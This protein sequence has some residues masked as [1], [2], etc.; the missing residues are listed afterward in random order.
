LGNN[1]HGV[2]E[3]VR[4]RLKAEG[5]FTVAAKRCN[6]CLF[7]AERLTTKGDATGIIR[8]TLADDSFFSCH[9]FSGVVETENASSSKPYSPDS[10]CCRGWFD[11][12][13]NATLPGRM[14]QAFGI[15]KFVDED[16][17]VVNPE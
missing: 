12:Y 13:G 8:R 7:S 15:V 14:A 3:E 10:V 5:G 11:A 4:Q 9:K 17:N 2:S 6:E 16:G 1:L